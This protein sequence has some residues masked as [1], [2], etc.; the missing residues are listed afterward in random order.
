VPR[1]L[2]S[3]AYCGLVASQ[4]W[5]PACDSTTRSA[6][7]SQGTGQQGQGCW[8]VA[9][10]AQLQLRCSVLRMQGHC[11]GLPLSH[12]AGAA[13]AAGIVALLSSI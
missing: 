4:V 7:W 3:C 8:L 11:Q 10:R 13:G 6:A 5:K 9:E 12:A 2:Q 1:L